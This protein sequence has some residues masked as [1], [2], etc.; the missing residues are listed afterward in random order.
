MPLYIKDDEVDALATELQ[1]LSGARSKTEAVRTALKDAIERKRDRKTTIRKAI[2]EA[3]RRVAAMGPRD[4]DF[5]MKEFMDD[6]SG[7]I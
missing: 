3:Q 4:P 7:G 1:A 6:L 5:D 2:A